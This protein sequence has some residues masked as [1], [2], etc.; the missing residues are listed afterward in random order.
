MPDPT[1]RESIAKDINTRFET[2]RAG[3]AF[4]VKETL[5]SPNVD[6]P[7]GKMIDA[8]SA[9]GQEFQNPNGFETRVPSMESRFKV[10]QSSGTKG[11]SKFV[12]GL[13]T[14]RYSNFQ[15]RRS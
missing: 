10:V 4:D 14:R 2:Q 11:V 9:N 3:G 12:R 13:D 5:G 8:K 15:P 1:N 6:V 7:A